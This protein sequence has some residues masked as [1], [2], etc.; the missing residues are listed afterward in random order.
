MKISRRTMLSRSLYIA[1][2]SFIVPISTPFATDNSKHLSKGLELIHKVLSRPLDIGISHLDKCL[3]SNKI[4]IENHAG[5][6]DYI[7]SLVTVFFGHHH[8]EDEIMFPTFEEKIKD[9][10]FSVLK[11]QHK[12]LHPLAEQIKHKIDIDNPTIENYREIRSLLQDTKDLWG[13]HREEEE[14]TVELDLEPVLS[15]KEQIE[16]SDKLGKHGQSMSSPAPLIL[17][18]LIYNLEGKDR[19]DFTREMPWILKKF[20]VPVLW[21]KKWQKMKPFLLT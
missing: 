6:K 15:L 7:S 20:I 16:L 19:R 5:F 21:K 1:I 18:F 14:Q 9:A 4:D 2:G 11:N 8:G 12:E 3:I 13:K 10:D 17:P